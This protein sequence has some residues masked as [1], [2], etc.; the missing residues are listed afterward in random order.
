ML[1]EQKSR[2]GLVLCAC[3]LLAG[4]D[5]DFDAYQATANGEPR[6]TSAWSAYGGSGGR[7]Y[8]P[9][10]R[11]NR[12]NVAELQLTWTYRTGD[13]E[14]VFQ[15]TPVLSE[16]RLLFCSPFN[17]VVALDPLTGNELWTFDPQVDRNLRPANEFNCRSVTP[18]HTGDAECPARVLMATNDARLMALNAATGQPC[19]T[20]GNGGE[21]ALDTDVGPLDWAGE[22][23]VTSPPVV[24]GELV[25]V[26]SAVSDGNRVTAPS[27][28][29]RAYHAVSGEQAWAFDLA[30]PGYEY[31]AQ[32]V[33]SA[34]YALG[35][36]NVWAPMV[37]DEAR[38][39]VF[40]PTGNPSPDYD[41]PPG[42]NMAYYGSAVVALRAS[43][44]EVL[45]HFNTVINDY[46]DFDVPS[47][48]VLAD[49][50]MN[51]TQVPA[52]IQAT[53][54]GHVFVLHRDTGQPLVDVTYE[55]VPVHGPLADRLSDVQPFPPSAFQVSRSYEK[56][57]SVFGLCD[58]MDAESVAGP[59]F[60]P[61]T[62]QWTIGL[63]SN[64]GATNWGGV[65]VDEERG[66]IVVNTNSVP[67]RTRLIKRQE[68]ADLL[69]VVEDRTAD[70]EAR[71]AAHREI[72]ARY[73]LPDDAELAMQQGAE[74]LMS[75]Q[76]YLDPVIGLPCAGPPLAEIMVIDI[77]ARA[78]IWRRHHGT[79]RDVTFI[80]LSI[81]MSGMGG[82]LLTQS[83]LI[84]IGAAAESR[85]RAYDVNTGDELWQHPLPFPG[86]ATPMSYTVD[87]PQGPR[88]FVVIAAGGDARAG[89]GGEGD[90]LVA[91]SL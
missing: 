67:F 68:V 11:I 13:T 76:A 32:P 79:T 59:V 6:T 33:S 25:I 42:R 77:N 75:R 85:L 43:T 60:T 22:Y 36:P 52:L 12:D 15:S 53:K 49:L 73:N 58:E 18:A 10:E 34:G 39:M 40:L 84:F 55:S 80:P 5:T 46:W 56:G 2:W 20:F 48:P 51:G 31:D 16:G 23:Q 91:F 78:Q 63:P 66:L 83:G 19:P 38:D 3:W 1:T 4:C 8:A 21:V 27:G 14:D 54:M 72:Y 41:R 62:E 47:Q 28:V 61:I 89:I 86:N 9:L 69:S 70:M 24:A 26:G 35:T 64:M 29:V 45:W 17:K 7:K 30:P 71:R 90:Y 81:G 74:H 82:S 65:A 50:T 57:E 44:G 88:Q 87:T 37:V